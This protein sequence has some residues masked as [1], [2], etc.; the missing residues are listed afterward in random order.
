MPANPML[1][2]LVFFF[3]GMYHTVLQRVCRGIHRYPLNY[4]SIILLQ[5][6]MANKNRLFLYMYTN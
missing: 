5:Y 1:S 2:A 3:G 4:P 6:H